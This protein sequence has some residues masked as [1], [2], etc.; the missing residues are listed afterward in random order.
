M[1]RTVTPIAQKDEVASAFTL[2]GTDEQCHSLNE[3]RGTNG[4]VVAFICNHCPY[5]KS[6]IDKIISDA[7]ELR[8]YGVSF[9]AINSNDSTHYTEDSFEKM[10]EVCKN[11][12]FPFPY[13][14]DD[15]QKVA[16]QYGA[17]CTPDFFGFNRDLKLQYRGRLCAPSQ[18]D[19]R[20]IREGRELF[21]AMKD[22][23]ATG[24]FKG[25]QLPSVGCSIK[26]KPR[27]E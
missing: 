10:K 4:T 9:I 17:V 16:L 6:I 25:V 24:V 2:L 7:L 20:F 11:F 1:V 14:V 22:I 27:V 21:I 12:R 8:D 26:W 19:S 3:L 23:A 13:L 5:V 15:T 18:E